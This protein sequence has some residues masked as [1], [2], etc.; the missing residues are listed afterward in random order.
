MASVRASTRV[1][2]AWSGEAAFEDTDTLVLTIEGWSL[3]LRVFNSGPAKGTIDWSTVAR[4]TTLPEST[5]GESTDRVL[6]CTAGEGTSHARLM[7]G[8]C[9]TEQRIL[10]FAGTT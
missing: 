9:L 4:V 8:M 3:D 6:D 2:I 7:H 1:S 10:S 5:P